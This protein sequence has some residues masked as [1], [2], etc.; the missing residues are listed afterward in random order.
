[1]AEDYGRPET[2]NSLTFVTSLSIENQKVKEINYQKSNGKIKK[3]TRRSQGVNLAHGRR[4]Q[5]NRIPVSR[6][7]FAS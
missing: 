6:K 2:V 7:T 1:M 4:L 3:R 5:T